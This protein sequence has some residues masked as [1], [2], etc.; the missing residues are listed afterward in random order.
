M[1]M[2][3]ERV[4]EDLQENST[5]FYNPNYRI[6]K[7]KKKI[8]SHFGNQIKFWRPNYRSE[9]VYSSHLNMGE[10]VEVVFE[11]ATPEDRILV[12]AA[13]ILHRHIKQAH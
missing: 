4:L 10:A 8:A 9:L 6:H 13:M 12:E 1:T 3:R 5:L 2:L 11:A 7:L